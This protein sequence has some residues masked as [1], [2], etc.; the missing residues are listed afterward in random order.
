MKNYGEFP[1]RL[2]IVLSRVKDDYLGR[3]ERGLSSV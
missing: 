2:D 1:E 3:L